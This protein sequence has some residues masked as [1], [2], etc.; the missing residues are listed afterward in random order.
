MRGKETDALSLAIFFHCILWRSEIFFHADTVEKFFCFET[1]VSLHV[2][3]HSGI[4]FWGEGVGGGGL[5]FPVNYAKRCILLFLAQL[6]N[7]KMGA[8]ELVF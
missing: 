2:M 8:T 6:G 3:Q 1:A 7:E 4:I 5:D